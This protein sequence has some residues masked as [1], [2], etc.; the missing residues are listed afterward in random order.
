M[1][2]SESALLQMLLCRGDVLTGW[3]VLD[4]LL[5]SPASFVQIGLRVGE[6]PLQI[7]DDTMV[8][9]LLAQIARVLGVY[10]IVCST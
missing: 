7:Y 2:L 3:Q 6:A 8:C 9:R 1:K 4:D 5:A 10:D